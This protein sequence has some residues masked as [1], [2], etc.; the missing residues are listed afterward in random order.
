MCLLLTPRCKTV[1][2][3]LRQHN[4]AVFSS[5]AVYHVSRQIEGLYW[6]QVKGDNGN[7]RWDADGFDAGDDTRS[8][9][10]FVKG[11]DYSDET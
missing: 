2:A 10:V 8:N 11:T 4:R 3:T 1:H 6:Q 9:N 7:A 5:Q